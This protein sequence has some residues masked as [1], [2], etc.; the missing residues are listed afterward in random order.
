ML[1]EQNYLGL[2]IKKEFMFPDDYISKIFFMESNE[3]HDIMTE[4]VQRRN[5]RFFGVLHPQRESLINILGQQGAHTFNKLILLY[6]E[7][8]VNVWKFSGEQLYGLEAKD[9]D[10]EFLE[11]NSRNHHINKYALGFINS[12]TQLVRYDM[13][14]ER[15]LEGF[16]T[17]DSDL[18]EMVF[19]MNAD[20]IFQSYGLEKFN[21]EIK[22]TFNT[23]DF[24]QS[25]IKLLDNNEFGMLMLQWLNLNDYNSI[26]FS[27]G[28]YKILEYIK[29]DFNKNN[30]KFKKNNNY[31][32]CL[33][34]L[35][36]LVTKKDSKYFLGFLND[37]V[38]LGVISRH[39]SSNTGKLQQVSNHVR[40]PNG[41]AF[42][43]QKS[44][45]QI[46]NNLTSGNNFP[47]I[48][49]LNYLYSFWHYTTSLII[50]SWFLTRKK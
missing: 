17:S 9:I 15:I 19:A 5:E 14:N 49:Q 3:S 35:I 41:L 10:L 30:D 46:Y 34:K 12:K 38:S 24:D 39:G 29:I 50:C 18:A 23:S 44:I 31:Y 1:E 6:L 8:A 43:N 26:D 48:M 20:K 7:A 47:S 21:I 28:I 45:E 2:N 33:E 25:I 36:K 22:E 16:K 13:K 11:T 32:E 37:T 40:I 27:A 4:H 42:N